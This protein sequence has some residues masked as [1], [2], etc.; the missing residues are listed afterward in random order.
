MMNQIS[1][2]ARH[3]PC[4]KVTMAVCCDDNDRTLDHAYTSS[5]T[6]VRVSD[7]L[8]DSDGGDAV[9]VGGVVAV[10]GSGGDVSVATA[11]VVVAVVADG[12][13][14]S[15]GDSFDGGDSGADVETTSSTATF[16]AT[17]ADTPRTTVS[18][19]LNSSFPPDSLSRAFITSCQD[20]Q[21]RKISLEATCIYSL[22]L[23]TTSSYS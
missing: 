15:G 9:A 2:L 18:N 11:V 4:T 21:H 22:Q 7:G 6:G 19:R 16:V 1:R 10:G 8:F 3:L 5:T 23:S 20:K 13:D 14:D 17:G 12:G